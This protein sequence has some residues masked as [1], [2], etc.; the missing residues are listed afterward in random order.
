MPQ[1]NSLDKINLNVL[2]SR[3]EELKLAENY[4]QDN[5]VI[6]PGAVDGCPA[7]RIYLDSGAHRPIVREELVKAEQYSGENVELGTC[8][9]DFY[10]YPVARISIEVAG[11]SNEIDIAADDNL[12]Y[13]ALLGRDF[14]SL[15]EVMVEEFTKAVANVVQTR[16]CSKVENIKEQELAELDAQSLH[17]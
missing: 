4:I 10:A 1:H 2:L 14:P 16:S 7:S 8:R 11:R 13:D 3:R 5:E 17:I 9:S 6:V 15:R 12:A